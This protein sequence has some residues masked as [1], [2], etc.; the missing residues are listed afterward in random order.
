MPTIGGIARLPDGQE[1]PAIGG[2]A[3]PHSKIRIPNSI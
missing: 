3:F 2:N 1:N